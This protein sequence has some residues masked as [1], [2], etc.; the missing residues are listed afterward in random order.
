MLTYRD[1]TFCR[2]GDKRNEVCRECVAFFDRAE[3]RRF[4]KEREEIPVAWFV[5]KA[6]DKEGT[7]NEP[8]FDFNGK[9]N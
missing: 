2:F 7:P 4:C 6:C 9:E 5:D 8:N 1:R 3:Y